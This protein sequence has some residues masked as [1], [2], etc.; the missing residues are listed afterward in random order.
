MEQSL[1]IA[2]LK[3]IIIGGLAGIHQ[4]VRIG[5]GAIIGA[6]TM[7]TKDVIPFGLCKAPEVLWMA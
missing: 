2:L 1:V 5:Q 7:V 3:M 6:V 4:F